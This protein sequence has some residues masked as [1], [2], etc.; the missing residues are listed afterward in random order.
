VEEGRQQNL[1]RAVMILLRE[2]EIV[3]FE[4]ACLDIGCRAYFNFTVL[5]HVHN[6]AVGKGWHYQIRKIPDT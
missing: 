6:G 3:T 5:M 2:P 4:F 1:A